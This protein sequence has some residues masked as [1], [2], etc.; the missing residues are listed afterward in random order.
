MHADLWD[1]NSGVFHVIKI[2]IYIYESNP[3]MEL[4]IKQAFFLGL[5]FWLLGQKDASMDMFNSLLSGHNNASSL[6]VKIDGE[7]GHVERGKVTD[8]INCQ[9]ER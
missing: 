8:V 1:F 7:L 6:T 5:K 2:T 4:L 3:G 9:G